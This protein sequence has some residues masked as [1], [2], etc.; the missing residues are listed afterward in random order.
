MENLQKNLEKLGFSEKETAVYTALL[1]FKLATVIQLAK[2]ADLKRT[3]VYHVLEELISKGLANKIIRNNTTYFFTEDP[4]INLNS[5]VEEKKKV[6]QLLI[7]ELKNIF[8]ATPFQPEIKM[9][10]DSA[11]MKKLILESLDS[12]EKIIRYYIS[13]LNVEELVGEDFVADFVK[14]RV[15]LGIKGLSL[16]SF[17]YKP[18]REKNLIHSKELREVRFLPENIEIKPYISIYDDKIIIIPTKEE[19]TS[20]LIRSKEFADAQKA[21]FDIIWNTVAI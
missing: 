10:R 2:A 6:I 12:K 7:P 17:K 8:G 3:T 9:Y 16:R 18:E 19:K 1:R 13:E 14:K 4:E 5:F 20:F 15:S 21:I 11:G